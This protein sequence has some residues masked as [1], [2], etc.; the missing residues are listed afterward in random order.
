[1]TCIVL[2]I[3][4]IFTRLCIKAVFRS[5]LCV[6]LHEWLHIMSGD[7]FNTTKKHDF[8]CYQ[9]Y[10]QSEMMNTLM[11]TCQNQQYTND[12]L[13]ATDCLL[14]KEWASVLTVYRVLKKKKY[15]KKKV[16]TFFL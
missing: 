5:I 9:M 2:D 6:Q 11:D 14:I 7:P 4:V 15:Q 13:F 16:H 1:M 12:I 10:R 8:D 3:I